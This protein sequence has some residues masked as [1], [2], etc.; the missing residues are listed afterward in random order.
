MGIVTEKHFANDY[1]SGYPFQAVMELPL[2]IPQ[3]LA[4]RHKSTGGV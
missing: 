2:A 3:G 1:L 4:I